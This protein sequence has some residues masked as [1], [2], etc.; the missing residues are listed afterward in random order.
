MFRRVE[1]AIW[2]L[3]EDQRI[4]ERVAQWVA[5][6]RTRDDRARRADIARGRSLAA[7]NPRSGRLAA[8]CAAGRT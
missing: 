5:G 6:G 1:P 7:S 2:A 8:T 3:L 4:T